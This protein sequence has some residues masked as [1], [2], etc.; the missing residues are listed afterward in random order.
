MSFKRFDDLGIIRFGVRSWH[1][2]IGVHAVF[3]RALYGAVGY[4]QAG[5]LF[6]PNLNLFIAVTSFGSTELRF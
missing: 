5:V 6:Q 1:L 2:E 4:V 3:D